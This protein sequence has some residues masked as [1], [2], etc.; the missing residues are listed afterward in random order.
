MSSDPKPQ[1][2]IRHFDGESAVVQTN[3]R[4]PDR[5]ELLKLKRRMSRI[6]FEERE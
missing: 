5:I 1:K 2:S 6:L 4:R 3:A